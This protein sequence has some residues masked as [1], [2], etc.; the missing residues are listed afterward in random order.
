MTRRPF[1]AIGCQATSLPAAATNHS[2]KR[3]KSE[4]L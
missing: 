3:R 1:G 2:V 4:N